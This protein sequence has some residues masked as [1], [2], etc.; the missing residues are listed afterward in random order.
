MKVYL[1]KLWEIKRFRFGCYGISV[2]FMI[3]FCMFYF[4]LYNQEVIYLNGVRLK[5]TDFQNGVT[6]YSGKYNTEEIKITATELGEKE[7]TVDYI[8]PQNRRFTYTVIKSPVNGSEGYKDEIKI[9]RDDNIIFDGYYISDNIGFCLFEKSGEPYW[10]AYAVSVIINNDDFPADY[11]PSPTIT[12]RL[13]YNNLSEKRGNLAFL[14]MFLFILIV[15]I[16]DI[17]YPLLFFKLHHFFAVK[18]PEPT[19]FYI[20]VQRLLW[21]VFYPILLIFCLVRGV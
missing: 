2:L 11:T 4:T 16:I 20:D 9:V 1:K 17:K 8:I 5:K 18:D 15:Y 13:A 3:L 10:G 19:D 21:Y 14:I 6:E 7:S 12:A